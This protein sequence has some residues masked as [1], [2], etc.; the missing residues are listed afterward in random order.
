MGKLAN[1]KAEMQRRLYNAPYKYK[2]FLRS[3][4]DQA[5]D[6]L[7]VL[8]PALNSAEMRL[9]SKIHRE[10]CRLPYREDPKGKDI[11]EIKQ[12]DE[13]RDCDDKTLEERKRLN[14]EVGIPRGA[15]RPQLC[16]VPTY[17]GWKGHMV[18]I[19]VL[20]DRDLVLDSN[21]ILPLPYPAFR[22]R[23][24]SRF[25]T[26]EKWQRPV[27]YGKI[28]PEATRIRSGERPSGPTE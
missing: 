15:L 20:A 2:A 14:V 1:Y 23:W 17:E 9:L 16:L 22:Y 26:D 6:G 18:L 8:F 24:C 11:W 7:K 28:A 3:H 12:G 4:P 27:F 13:P 5:S 21:M 19:L 10:I 25:Y